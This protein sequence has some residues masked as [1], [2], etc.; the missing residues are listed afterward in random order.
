MKPRISPADLTSLL[1]ATVAIPSQ[2]ELLAYFPFDSDFNDTSGKDN[3]LTVTE[4]EPTITNSDGDFVFGNG[5]LDTDSTTSD[6]EFLTLTNPLVFGE[7]DPWTIAFWAKRREGSD[8]RQ[9]MVI[10]DVENTRDFV[11]LSNNPTQVQGVRFR[12][13]ANSNFNFEVGED[14]AQWHHWA[15]VA[16]GAGNLTV[17]R[18][19]VALGTQSSNTTFS[20]KDVAQAYNTNVHSMN[21]QIDELYIYDE[22]LDAATVDALFQGPSE[23]ELAITAF[24]YSTETGQVTLSWSS[25]PGQS[26]EVKFSDNLTDWSG[27][28][29]AA[30]EADSEESSITFDPATLGLPDAPRVFFRVEKP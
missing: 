15:L 9:G 11:W 25:S 26:Y 10:G 28:V 22:A 5:A 23:S 14:D 3:H 20:V 2:A 27:Q 19:N 18:D 1:L 21:G 16:D 17:Y 7:S 29:G 13:S 6:R 24:E 4:G 12:S 8:N 30:I